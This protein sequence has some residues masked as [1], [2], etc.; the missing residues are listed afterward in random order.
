MKKGTVFQKESTLSGKSCYKK[1]EGRP[2]SFALKVLSSE[3][4]PVEIRL[5]RQIF[6]KG[7]IAAAF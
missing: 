4:D 6:I 1:E 2:Y 3:M 5:I 7:S